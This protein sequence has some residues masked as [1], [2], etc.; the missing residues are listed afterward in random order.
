VTQGWGI[1]VGL[2]L[3]DAALWTG[4]VYP[5]R[6]P[7]AARR[8]QHYCRA[9]AGFR[10]VRPGGRGAHGDRTDA[11]ARRGVRR[12][13]VPAALR[14]AA[15]TR[16]LR[17]ALPD[18]LDTL[19]LCLRA[20]LGLHAAVAEYAKTAT[21]MAGDAFRGYLADLALGQAPDDALAGLARRFPL[22]EVAALAAAVAQSLRIGAPLAEVFEMQAAHYR[23]MSLHRAR[24]AAQRLSTQLVLPLVVFIFPVVFLV[25]LGPVALKVGRLIGVIR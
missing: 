2:A 5:R 24:E 3:V 13:L 25:G 6:Q 14:R 15:D 22:D 19:A 21:G 16:A 7:A 12:F 1:V 9:A 8:L 17:R 4:C 23:T 20:G 18:A 11:G 10:I